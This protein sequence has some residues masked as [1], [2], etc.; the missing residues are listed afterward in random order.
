MQM[1]IERLCD[2]SGNSNLV[3][4]GHRLRDNHLQTYKILLIDIPDSQKEGQVMNNQVTYCISGWNF[5]FLRYIESMAYLSQ[6]V[7]ANNLA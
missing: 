7:L 2:V 3:H 5:Y 6:T 1:P 4:I